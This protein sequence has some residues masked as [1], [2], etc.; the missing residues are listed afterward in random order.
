MKTEGT[1]LLVLTMSAFWG[2]SIPSGGRYRQ[3]S[4][5]VAFAPFMQ[6]PL[7]RTPSRE[8]AS[9]C[10]WQDHGTAWHGDVMAWK[11]FRITVPLWGESSGRLFCITL[12][13]R[14]WRKGPDNNFWRGRFWRRG[15]ASLSFKPTNM[16]LQVCFQWTF[17]SRITFCVTYF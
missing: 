13:I 9:T 11:R 17:I 6:P 7:A 15:S 1:N 10:D 14:G 8:L 4:L 2:R 16:I 3:V 12:A 5:Y